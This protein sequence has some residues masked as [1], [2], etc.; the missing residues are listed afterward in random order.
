MFFR[1]VLSVIAGCFDV[2]CPSPEK[3]DAA[4]VGVVH[5]KREK[6][7][8]IEVWLG[9]AQPPPLD[10]VRRVESFLKTDVP[11]QW[12]AYKAFHKA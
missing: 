1:L 4:V 11:G 5:S 9:G 3:S 8:R 2:D 6:H 10:W 12:F 7:S